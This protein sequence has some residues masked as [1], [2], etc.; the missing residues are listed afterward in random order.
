MKAKKIRKNY[1]KTNKANCINR[2]QITKKNKNK[3]KPPKK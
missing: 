2:K 3:Q 1:K